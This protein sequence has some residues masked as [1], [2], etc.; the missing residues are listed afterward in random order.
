[1]RIRGGGGWESVVDSVL[2]SNEDVIKEEE[3]EEEGVDAKPNVGFESRSDERGPGQAGS[4]EHTTQ[5]R[6]YGE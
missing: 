6:N 2:S 5:S 1:M 4:L 3:E